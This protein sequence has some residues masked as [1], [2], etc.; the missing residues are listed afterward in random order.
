MCLHIGILVDVATR[1]EVMIGSTKELGIILSNVCYALLGNY[2]MMNMNK[3]VSRVYAH[4]PCSQVKSTEH[5][6][7]KES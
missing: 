3:I 5:P 7:C 1:V 2:S 4:K 6:H